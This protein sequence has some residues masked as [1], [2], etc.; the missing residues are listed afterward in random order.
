MYKAFEVVDFVNWENGLISDSDITQ[1]LE[2]RT[3]TRLNLRHTRIKDE[4]LVRL[5]GLP[6][7]RLVLLEGSTAT[8][9]GI[10]ELQRAL[11]ALTIK[12]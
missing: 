11:P 6:H 1:L 5:K 9:A 12:R 4:D 10:S 7:L 3:L 8:E 2:L